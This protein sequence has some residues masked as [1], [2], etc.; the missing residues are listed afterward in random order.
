MHFRLR[1]RREMFNKLLH[2]T[3]LQCQSISQTRHNERA[4]ILH[5]FDCTLTA[6]AGESIIL[7]GSYFVI[8]IS[9][10]S[11]SKIVTYGIQISSPRL[12]IKPWKTWKLVRRTLGKVLAMPLTSLKPFCASYVSIFKVYGQMHIHEGSEVNPWFGKR[13]RLDPI[14]LMLFLVCL[15]EMSWLSPFLPT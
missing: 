9:T 15:N 5:P 3:T 12:F 7:A 13:P 6:I 14:M 2:C 1:R 10:A 8:Y 11:L 4:N